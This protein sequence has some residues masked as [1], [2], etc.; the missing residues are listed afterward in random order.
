MLSILIVLVSTGSV[1]LLVCRRVAS[2][3]Y[4][5]DGGNTGQRLLLFWLAKE[6]VVMRTALARMKRYRLLHSLESMA[7]AG[8]HNVL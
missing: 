4:S 7:R 5:N 8:N 1:I 3:R 6:S 2:I